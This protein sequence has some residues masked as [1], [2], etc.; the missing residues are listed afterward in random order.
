MTTRTKNFP[1]APPDHFENLGEL[2]E[3]I[4][5]IDEVQQ[6]WLVGA[7]TIQGARP[8]DLDLVIDYEGDPA[9]VPEVFEPFFGAFVIVKGMD[10]RVDTNVVRETEPGAIQRTF[11][12]PDSSGR[13]PNPRLLFRR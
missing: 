9:G 1:D 11:S 3:E 4:S 13:R 12:K 8:N 2:V 7:M 10:L 6:I 5:T